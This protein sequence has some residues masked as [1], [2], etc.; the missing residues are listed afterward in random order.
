MKLTRQESAAGF[1]SAEA[2]KGI[3]AAEFAI[4]A[5][6]LF[7]LMMGMF[8]LSRAIMVK[9]TLS[10]SAR[11][12]C[13]TGVL[14]AKTYTDIVNDANNILQDNKIDATKATIVVQVARYQGGST[15]PTWGTFTTVN[16]ASFAPLALDKYPSPF[17]YLFRRFSG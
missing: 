2:R 7:A 9:E 12:G 3:A 11:K 16:S 14:A 15:T 17:P 5:P 13:G 4:L 1:K 6:F 10:N 8:E